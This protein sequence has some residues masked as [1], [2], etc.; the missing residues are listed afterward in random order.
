[1]YFKR[2]AKA[3]T[4]DMV[5]TVPP[6]LKKTPDGSLVDDYSAPMPTEVFGTY[7]DPL[8]ALEILATQDDDYRY[9]LWVL[10][11]HSRPAPGTTRWVSA[12]NS[13]DMLIRAFGR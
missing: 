11:G 13:A 10:K 1:A 4:G 9:L 3:P 8:V 7:R 5:V 2:V 6:P 12:K